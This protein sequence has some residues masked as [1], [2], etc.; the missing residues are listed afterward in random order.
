[1]KDD[2]PGG[3]L[4]SSDSREAYWP[5]AEKRKRISV[6]DP[7]QIQSPTRYSISGSHRRLGGCAGRPRNSIPVW[8]LLTDGT[9][10]GGGATDRRSQ[11]GRARGPGSERRSASSIGR[12]VGQFAEQRVGDD[13]DVDADA[14]RQLAPGD[15]A[16]LR[17]YAVDQHRTQQEAPGIAR[18]IQPFSTNAGRAG[19][20]VWSS[21]Y[22]PAD[23]TMNV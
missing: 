1:M 16:F 15:D 3:M 13:Q 23:A 9:G 17:P 20:A 5:S 19:V 21:S 7:V 11:S 14:V 8:E 12:Y 10:P 4:Y 2:P 6:V 18:T 22:S